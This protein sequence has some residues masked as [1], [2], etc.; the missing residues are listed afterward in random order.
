MSYVGVVVLS[1]EATDA[2]AKGEVLKAD[3]VPYFINTPLF[4]T[5][6][7]KYGWLNKVQAIGKMVALKRT[8]AE[9]YV[10]YDIF[11]AR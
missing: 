10:T 3:S 9:A 1:K 5:S 6:S 4:Q 11:I 2:L 8:P 7:E